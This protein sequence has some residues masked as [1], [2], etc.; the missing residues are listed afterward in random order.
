MTLPNTSA[1]VDSRRRSRG[2][3]GFTL[4]ESAI[5]TVITGFGVMGMLQLLAAGSLAN[6]EGTELTTAINLA[7]NV[8]EMCLGMPF[9]DPQ[10]PH[11]GKVHPITGVMDPKLWD[12]KEPSVKEYDNVL[13]LD[14]CEF[15]PPLDVRRDPINNYADWKQVVRIE[16]VAR[17]YLASVRPDTTLEPTVRMTVTIQRHGHDVYKTSSLITAPKLD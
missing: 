13:D 10:D 12:T 9:Y 5:V 16:T 2:R 15:S 8:R 4:I 17:D 6:A 11:T 14:D 7:H 1:W 3:R